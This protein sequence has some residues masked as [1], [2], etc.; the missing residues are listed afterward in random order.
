LSMS[1]SAGLEVLFLED[2]ETTTSQTPRRSNRS[3][4]RASKMDI[5]T[6]RSFLSAITATAAAVA[7]EDPKRVERA[8]NEHKRAVW[9]KDGWVRDPYIILAPDDFY[10]YTGTTQPPGQPE[11]VYNTGLGPKSKVGWHVQAWR[12]RRASGPKPKGADS[13]VRHKAN[14]ACG[15]RSSTGW[16]AAGP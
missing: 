10:Y 2:N 6:R 4:S 7:A 14:G 5:R 15:L 12:S 16:M 1:Y 8:L 13:K 3:Y 9:V 11:E